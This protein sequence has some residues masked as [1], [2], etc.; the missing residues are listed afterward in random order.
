MEAKKTTA[1][2]SSYKHKFNEGDIVKVKSK[3]SPLYGEVC[4][5]MMRFKSGAYS[6]QIVGTHIRC[7]GFGRWMEHVPNPENYS[8]VK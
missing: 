8:D 3:H 4:C 1:K 6:L 2:K 5:V 7:T